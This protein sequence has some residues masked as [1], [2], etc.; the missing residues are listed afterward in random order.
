[1]QT[2]VRAM[3]PVPTVDQLFK[4]TL[5]V[6]Q[7]CL[8]D[9]PAE[10]NCECK[11]EWWVCEREGYLFVRYDCSKFSTLTEKNAQSHGLWR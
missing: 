5:S 10:K 7:T 8:Y 11:K 4:R 1:M 9:K 6:I 3:H 2:H